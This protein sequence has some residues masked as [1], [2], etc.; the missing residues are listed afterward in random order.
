MLSRGLCCFFSYSLTNANHV[1]PRGRNW[2]VLELPQVPNVLELVV[3]IK[4]AAQ[5]QRRRTAR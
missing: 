2:L 4:E 3:L 1:G 5:K